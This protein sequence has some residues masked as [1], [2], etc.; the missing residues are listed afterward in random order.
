MKQLQW[1]IGQE[2]DHII[3]KGQRFRISD[4]G[5]PSVALFAPEKSNSIQEA[6]DFRH[7]KTD[8][9]APVRHFGS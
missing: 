8:I 2:M 4:L 9:N 1:V 6:V 5:E 3:V 7:E